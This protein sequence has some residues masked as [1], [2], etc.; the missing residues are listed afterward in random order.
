MSELP[1]EQAAKDAFNKIKEVINNLSKINIAVVGKTGVGKSTLI[2]AVFGE[3]FAKA[4][5]GEPV[6]TEFR[7]Y[8]KPESPL[9]I[10]DSPGFDMNEHSPEAVKKDLLK[11]IDEGIASK[12]MDKALHC[13]WYCI[14]TASD[15]VEDTELKWLAEFTAE[16]KRYNVPV[17]IILTKSYSRKNAQELKN[18]ID[19]KM[20]P[21]KKV[22]PVLAQ[23]FV[24]DD[25]VVSKAFGLDELVAV[26]GAV[27]P[28]D[29]QKTW[30]NVQKAALEDKVKYARRIVTANAVSAAG[31]GA[32]PIPFTDASVLVPLQITM[33]AEIT[34]V[35]GINVS[36]SFMTAVLAS[37]LGTGGATVL[38]RTVVSNLIKLI[39][40]AGTIVGGAISASTAGVI[41]TALG[42]SYIAV[43]KMLFSGEMTLDQFESNDGKKRISDLFKQELKK[44]KQ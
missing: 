34:A 43:M 32:S 26:M 24:I 39:P 18:V 38:G 31:V 13:I 3:E 1:V 19:S 28:E 35:F 15:R 22:I 17:I 36:K 11:I 12:D 16:N 29:L 14:S 25:V 4:C 40:G 6:T 10:Y 41:T 21:V 7:K 9:A 30:Q 33:I 5:V 37:T 44:N 8:T 27:L 23:D 2:N 20:L 42:N